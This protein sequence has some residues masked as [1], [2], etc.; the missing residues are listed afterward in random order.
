VE[1][2]EVH[3]E[4]NNNKMGKTKTLAYLLSRYFIMYF[5]FILVGM[6]TLINCVALFCPNY[7]TPKIEFICVQFFGA[8]FL[9][10]ILMCC[11]CFV[12]NSSKW[13][14]ACAI[15]EVLFFFSNIL[16]TDNLNYNIA[17]QIIISI[18]LPIISYYESIIK[19]AKQINI[20]LF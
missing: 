18:I 5:C 13:A 4:V 20:K 10:S 12:F 9:V 17:L 15:S 8:N 11:I 1:L 14:W 6:Q 16:I 19:W 2:V 7:Y 3:Q